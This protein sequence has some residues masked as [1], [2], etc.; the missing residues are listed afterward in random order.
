MRFKEFVLL[1]ED[2]LAAFGEITDGLVGACRELVE[3]VGR[4]CRAA[5]QLSRRV[6]ADALIVIGDELL[7]L[8]HRRGGHYAVGAFLLRPR[9]M[10]YG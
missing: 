8:V 10:K 7:H 6:S 2:L 5:R 4:A 9:Q 3:L 1:G